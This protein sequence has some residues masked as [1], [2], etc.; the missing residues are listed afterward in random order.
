MQRFVRLLA[1]VG[2]ILLSALSFN[3]SAQTCTPSAG[4]TIFF[5][6]GV[7]NNTRDSALES[8][9]ALEN[10]TSGSNGASIY[11]FEL[12][13]NPGNGYVSDLIEAAGQ[14]YGANLDLATFTLWFTG[15]AVPAA[16]DA[17]YSKDIG[18]PT[19]QKFLPPYTTAEVLQQHILQYRAAIAS[20][21]KIV[22]VAHSQGNFFANAAV[23]SQGNSLT[24][25]EALSFTIVSVANPDNHIAT[26]VRSRGPVTL[27]EDQV[28]EGLVVIGMPAE[29]SNGYANTPNGDAV[30]HRFNLSYLQQGYD[31]SVSR[32]G[33]LNSLQAILSRI[34][35]ADSA[36]VFPKCPS[37]TQAADGDF[38]AWSFFSFVTDDP[39]T[40]T[41]G[42][43]T[44]SGTVTRNTTG[45]NPGAYLATALT[46]TYGDTIWTGGIKTDFQYN[47]ASSGAIGTVSVSADVTMFSAGATAWQLVIEQ[48][49]KRY[50][51]FPLGAF[52]GAWTTVTRVGL[53]AANFDTNP[54]AGNPGVLPDGVRP[55]FGPAALPIKFGFMVGNRLPGPGTATAN[56][57]ID[58]F[59]VT[60]T[61]GIAFTDN[62]DRQNGVVG[63]DWT[64][65]TDNVGGALVISANKLTAPG[66][67]GRAGIY[68]RIGLT[69][70]VAASATITQENG[71]YG[72]LL[73]RYTT[74]FLFGS[75]TNSTS[76][77][78]VYFSRGDSN[79][80]DSA[81]VLMLNGAQAGIVS[82]PANLQFGASLNV[83]AT[84]NPTDGS[85]SGTV[86]VGATSF[87]YSFPPLAAAR[88]T[89]LPGTNF[90][91]DQ[92][93]PGAN[94]PPLT[95]PTIDNF[96]LVSG[97]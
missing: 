96:S 23:E 63:N 36:T 90:G 60:I 16:I 85:V 48:G 44:S 49:G 94:S 17:A 52:T 38:A 9:Y 18:L 87:P 43:G 75:S 32:T 53:T 20:G 5:I 71:F 51:S 34:S 50:Y 14:K 69:M 88:A 37:D 15:E 3:I 54:W 76:G 25:A 68:R 89:V 45:G 1:F 86:L 2:V 12:A 46:M 28:L 33:P 56:H 11:D 83:T 26:N 65:M 64:N 4:T 24:F 84:Y 57:G 40:A 91:I 73:N 42:P 35:D 41:P 80:T 82:L 59:A 29:Y 74:G 6:N 61:K 13:Y 62:F 7:Y 22:A 47:P 79:Y 93:F 78:G 72:Y 70:P 67:N 55:D 97:G 10:Y 77:Y 92:G 95:L 19:L 81:I 58:N 39:Y 8:L 30:K 66:P 21:K 31:S 27:T